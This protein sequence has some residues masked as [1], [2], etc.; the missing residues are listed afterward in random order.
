MPTATPRLTPAGQRV[1]DTASDLFYREGLHAVGVEAIAAA[2]GVTKK[3]LYDR[4]GSKDN[5]I[6]AYLRARDEI[7]RAFLAGHLDR[8][9]PDSR[10]RLLATFDALEERIRTAN[11]R[12]CAF[13]NALAEL[14]DPAHPARTVIVEQKEWMVDYLTG[15]AAEAGLRDPEALG[16]TVFLL[17]EGATVAMASDVPH[18]PMQHAKAAA[19]EL[20][21]DQCP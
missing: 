13:H 7:W 8:V 15:L 18:N 14:P 2:A 9:G 3:T 10:K 21:A 17:Q 4:F 5:L 12:G 16:R 11:P 19:A 1:L 20:I 6:V